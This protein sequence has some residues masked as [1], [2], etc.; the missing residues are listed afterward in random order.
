MKMGTKKVKKVHSLSLQPEREGEGEKEGE[1]V[2]V[3]KMRKQMIY[4]RRVN[5][6]S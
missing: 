4:R 1:I 2:I 3:R 5:G 6:R